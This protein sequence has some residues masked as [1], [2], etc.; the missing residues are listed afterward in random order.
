MIKSKTLTEER[1]E[2]IRFSSLTKVDRD[3]DSSDGEKT[4]RD[5]YQNIQHVK[6]CICVVRMV[7]PE[8]VLMCS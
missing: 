5:E 4:K 6:D 3:G 7:R 8:F 1:T 2:K